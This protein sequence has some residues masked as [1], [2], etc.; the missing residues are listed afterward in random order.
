MSN[1]DLN[2]SH[3]N[4]QTS[5]LEVILAGFDSL[6]A[7]IG[8]VGGKKFSRTFNIVNG[9]VSETIEYGDSDMNQNDLEKALVGLTVGTIAGGVAG[10]IVL[11][12]G[13]KRE[14]S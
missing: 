12:G 10:Q 11:G 3:T 7:M 14:V 8:T 5:N 9:V 13:F 1:N 4:N 6:T 2:V